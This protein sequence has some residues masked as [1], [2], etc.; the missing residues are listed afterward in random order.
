MRPIIPAVETKAHTRTMSLSQASP[1]P[2]KPSSM[3]KTT[4]VPAAVEASKEFLYSMSAVLRKQELF[5]ANMRKEKQQW[6]K[7]RDSLRHEVDDIKKQ[8]EYGEDNDDLV[9]EGELQGLKERLQALKTEFAETAEGE[10]PSGKPEAVL[11]VSKHKHV[12]FEPKE[13]E[14]LR[15]D[16]NDEH[17]NYLEELEKLRQELA[18]VKS[19]RE[20]I[21][22]LRRELEEAKAPVKQEIDN[23]L[24]ELTV[25]RQDEEEV[26]QYEE[27]SLYSEY[28]V[29]TVSDAG[30]NC[31]DAVLDSSCCS[32]ASY[33]EESSSTASMTSV[34]D[35]IYEEEE[36]GSVEENIGKLSLPSIVE[37]PNSPVSVVE[38]PKRCTGN[39][40]PSL[41]PLSVE[42]LSH[43]Q[44]K[45]KLLK[46]FLH[47][48]RSLPYSFKNLKIQDAQTSSGDTLH[49]VMFHN[50]W[51]IPGSLRDSA[52]DYLVTHTDADDALQQKFIWPFC[53]ASLMERQFR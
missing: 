48:H 18:E 7:E 11:K 43:A 50:R 22:L 34:A 53:E 31:F 20:E 25:L 44:R 42:A 9:E 5:L 12:H 19:S 39:R 51:Y 15:R 35:S 3:E 27:E 23:I 2:S 16:L 21:Q 41:G 17:E 10:A 45:D 47:D 24:T 1:Q 37:A 13:V 4:I 36:I 28:E 14:N 38:T 8:L 32:D 52:L 26:S 46:A 33:S 40:L 30:S 29:V 49:L 6:E